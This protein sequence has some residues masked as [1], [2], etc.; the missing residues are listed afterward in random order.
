MLRRPGSDDLPGLDHLDFY[1]PALPQVEQVLATEPSLT[2]TNET[3]DI[4][5][6][7]HW[8]SIWFAGTEAKLKPE[9]VLEICMAELRQLNQRILGKAA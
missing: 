9:T 2:W 7:Y 6:D 4:I 3:N 8:I 1:S 5:E